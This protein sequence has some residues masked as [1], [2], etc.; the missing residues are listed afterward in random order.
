[1]HGVLCCFCINGFTVGMVFEI[2]N[3][4]VSLALELFF[5]HYLKET[6]AMF[7]APLPYVGPSITVCIYLYYRH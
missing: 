5:Y 7:R 4:L 6:Y 2:S 3:C 1:M